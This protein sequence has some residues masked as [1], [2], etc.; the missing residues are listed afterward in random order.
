[1]ANL[2]IN[3]QLFDGLSLHQ[4]INA[5]L[6]LQAQ[7]NSA[8]EKRIDRINDVHGDEQ[9]GSLVAFYVAEDVLNKV[10]EHLID[11]TVEKFGGDK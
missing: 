4:R 7:I 10:Q 11:S 2:E 1:M 5:M 3:T 6:E 8:T 9:N